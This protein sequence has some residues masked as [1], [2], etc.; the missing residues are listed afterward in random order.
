MNSINEM[1][2]NVMRKRT[3][4][5]GVE[6]DMLLGILSIVLAFIVGSDGTTLYGQWLAGGA[7]Q[8]VVS[9][10]TAFV[11]GMAGLMIIVLR[12]RSATWF[13][14]AGLPLAVFMM[15]TG[16]AALRLGEPAS[17]AV[18]SFFFVVYLYQTYEFYVTSH[19]KAEAAEKKDAEIATLKEQVTDLQYQLNSR[20]IPVQEKAGVGGQ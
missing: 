9:F 3:N 8:E 15:L 20:L 17:G 12:P 19:G 2:V 13:L 18:I 1:A 4:F 14:V 6:P 5:V 10:T 16:V 11:L 7:A